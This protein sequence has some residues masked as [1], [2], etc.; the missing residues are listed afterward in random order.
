MPTVEVTARQGRPEETSADTRIVGLFEGESLE[1]EELQALVDS[2]EAK[3]GL[4]KLAVTHERAA[5]GSRRVIVV[6]LG[7][8]DEF[9]AERARVAAA[10]AA[11]RA[12]D[13]SAKSLSWAAPAGT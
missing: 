11:Q 7:K 8:R 5:S 10:V 12:R 1:G 2:G 13:L 4:R 6:G 3:G 9:D